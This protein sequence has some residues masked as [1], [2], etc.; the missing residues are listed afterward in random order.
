MS[1]YGNPDLNRIEGLVNPAKNIA[2]SLLNSQ[3]TYG[4]PDLA[5]TRHLVRPAEKISPELLER[6]HIYGAA[7]RRN[8][9]GLSP[10]AEKNVKEIFK[11]MR[12]NPNSKTQDTEEE[13]I[14]Y[15]KNS[16]TI[17][18]MR[19]WLKDSHKKYEGDMKRAYATAALNYQ[20]GHQQ[21]KKIMEKIK[22]M[23]PHIDFGIHGMRG[24]RPFFDKPLSERK[25]RATKRS[26]GGKSKKKYKKKTNRRIK[27]RSSSRKSRK[28]HSHR[29]RRVSSSRKR[30]RR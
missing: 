9:P 12:E 19:D 30:R 11:E 28:R 20:H 21:S 3:N 8:Y 29:R 23:N 4:N 14:E 5:N 2:P 27:R 22:E 7:D 16:Y 15:G 18:E 10:Q 1:N 25:K 17:R 24:V 26:R 13:D 6:Q